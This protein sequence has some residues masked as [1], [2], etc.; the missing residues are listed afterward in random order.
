M[1]ELMM[2]RFPYPDPD[3]LS[4]AKRTV[5]AGTQGRVLNVS[6]MAMHAPDAL[7]LG[8]RQLGRAAVYES[9]LDERL[10]ELLI[11][12]VAYLSKSDY[13]LFHHLSIAK[14]LG[15]TAEQIDAMRTGDFARLSKDEQALAQFVTEIV[16]NVSPSD[17]TLERA[18]ASFPTE[19]LFEMVVLCGSYMLTARMAALGGVEFDDAPVASWHK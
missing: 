5:L 15:V 3:S 2:T 11:L 10:R 7:W 19:Q 8:Q 12:R 4:E 6:R 14:N 18:R 9:T 16:A 13:E 17:A 1:P